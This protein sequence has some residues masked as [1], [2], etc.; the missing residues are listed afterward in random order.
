MC[1]DTILQPVPVLQAARKT[2]KCDRSLPRVCLVP[3]LDRRISTERLEVAEDVC[4]ESGIIVT[5]SSQTRVALANVRKKQPIGVG[6]VC[7]EVHVQQNRRRLQHYTLKQ[8]HAGIPKIIRKSR[9]RRPAQ[10]C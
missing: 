10:R 6:E 7:C 2:L 8:R 3:Y 5:K 9:P 4:V 1:V